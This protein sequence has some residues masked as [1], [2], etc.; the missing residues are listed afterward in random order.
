[1]LVQVLGSSPWDVL[2]PLGVWSHVGSG[3]LLLSLATR[4]SQECVIFSQDPELRLGVLNVG[5]LIIRVQIVEPGVVMVRDWPGLQ[6][7]S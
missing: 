4:T 5:Q 2:G 6:S 1:V 7:G 3:G